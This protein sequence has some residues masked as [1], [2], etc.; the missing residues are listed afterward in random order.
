VAR[1]LN[2]FDLIRQITDEYVRSYHPP[3]TIRARLVDHQPAFNYTIYCNPETGAFGFT[4]G[5]YPPDSSS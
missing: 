5:K 4:T 3:K 2:L 1:G